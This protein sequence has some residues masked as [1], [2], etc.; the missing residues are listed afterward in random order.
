[1]AEGYAAHVLAYKGAA[2]CQEGYSMGGRGTYEA[3]E[4]TGSRG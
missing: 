2:S 3:S 4:G 1:M